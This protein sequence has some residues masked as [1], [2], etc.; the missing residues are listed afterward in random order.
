MATGSINISSNISRNEM[1][2]IYPPN[3]C[4]NFKSSPGEA[5][6]FLWW[7]DPNEPYVTTDSLV[8]EWSYTRIVRKIGQ[9][10]SN[11][12][13]GSIVT[14]SSVKNQYKDNPYIDNNLLNDVTYYYAAF[15]CSTSGVFNRKQIIT[16][17][18]PKHFKIMTVT[19]DLN[20]SN[21]ATCGSYADDAKGMESGKTESATTMW[22]EFFGYR[23][24][25]FKDGKVVGYLNP[26]D[27][28]KFEDGKTADITS[29]NSGDVMVEFPRHGL[30]I[31]KSGKVVTVSM[32]DNPN[33]PEFKYYAHQR[34]QINKDFFYVGAY[35]GSIDDNVNN[36]RPRLRSVSGASPYTPDTFK[37]SETATPLISNPINN[38]GILSFYQWTYIQ[39]MYILQF[40]GNLNSQTALGYGSCFNASW[41]H[42]TG[43]TNDKGM[44]Y[45]ITE[46]GNNPEENTVKLFGI[47]DIWGHKRVILNNVYTCGKKPTLYATT[48][49]TIDDLTMYTNCGDLL[50][51]NGTSYIQGYMNDCIGTSDGGFAPTKCS[52]SSSTYFCDYG[53]IYRSYDAEDKFAFTVG[54]DCGDT[55]K[56]GIFYTGVIDKTGIGS[57][58][59]S[60]YV[61]RLQYL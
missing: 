8:V 61:F 46:K 6:V 43:V 42:D 18:T 58:T 23:P 51:T 56:C 13:D 3:S 12:N 28:T 20:K 41:W 47:E 10:P 19:I 34:G 14:E 5:S 44:T 57:N 31:S 48:D 38:Y 17:A 24:C 33:N 49:D 25:L 36:T 55:D 40:R 45:G 30:R 4:T 37:W 26:N 32:T 7:E 59:D 52:G 53:M 1:L 15:T 11:E 39:A 9:Y 35:F 21:P 50:N 16:Q 60:K 22:K 2:A 27:Y 54:G 29:G